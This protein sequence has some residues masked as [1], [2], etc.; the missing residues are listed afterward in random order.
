MG[1]GGASAWAAALK[2]GQKQT[3]VVAAAAV[4]DRLSVA[5]QECGSSM[6]GGSDSA[7]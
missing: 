7:L 4:A 2:S 3:G 1:G 5:Q 6:S